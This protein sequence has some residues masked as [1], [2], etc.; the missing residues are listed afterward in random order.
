MNAFAFFA[1]EYQETRESILKT[2]HI[3]FVGSYIICSVVK[4]DT[5]KSLLYFEHKASVFSNQLFQ[6][7]LIVLC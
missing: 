3:L 6:I 2:S 5:E 1:F 7:V 4:I